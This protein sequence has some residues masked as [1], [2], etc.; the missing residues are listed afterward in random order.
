MV[1]QLSHWYGILAIL[2]LLVHLFPIAPTPVSLTPDLYA[3]T[4]DRILTQRVIVMDVSAVIPSEWETALVKER[5]DLLFFGEDIQEAES[6]RVFWQDDSSVPVNGN[7]G[8]IAI[9]EDNGIRGYDP[10]GN[11]VNNLN[12]FIEE[13]QL[14]AIEPPQLLK[15][16][17]LVYAVVDW[18]Q[19]RGFVSFLPFGEEVALI[20]LSNT[21]DGFEDNRE[22]LF[23]LLRLIRQ[24]ASDE[25]MLFTAEDDEFSAMIP[26]SWLIDNQFAEDS[27]A[28]FFAE[29]ED[30]L[31]NFR[32]FWDSN[33]QVQID[34]SGGLVV[35][36][37][38]DGIINI[39]LN[40]DEVTN[41]ENVIAALELDIIEAVQPVQQSGYNGAI[42]V[43]DWGNQ[44]AF[45]SLIWLE[46]GWAFF[47][48][49]TPPKAFEEN[50]DL[51][52]SISQS[53][54]FPGVE[55][56]EAFVIAQSKTP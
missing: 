24:P 35:F 13:L 20:Y 16:T 53:F 21:I 18:G 54:V 25:G 2:F 47:V 56:F 51:L 15:G 52:L 40:A 38:P 36:F 48:I 34:G 19:Q 11:L 7:G 23:T 14:K 32:I 50:Q 45:I 4:D 55:D 44:R 10:N 37:P 12:N 1:K 6:R 5:P 33:D 29:N 39:D 17:P 43:V 49:G 27:Q 3:Q 8:L 41:L 9:F 31:E 30:E 42:A 46:D 26:F 28:L 22:L